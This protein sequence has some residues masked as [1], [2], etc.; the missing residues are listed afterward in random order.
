MTSPEIGAKD[1]FA[2]ASNRFDRYRGQ[3]GP[4]CGRFF[5]KNQ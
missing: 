3:I 1:Q 4:H 2:P 5:V